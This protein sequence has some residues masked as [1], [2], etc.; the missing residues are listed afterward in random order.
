MPAP[1][2]LLYADVVEHLEKWANQRG[3]SPNLELI[4]WSTVRA[5]E[6]V[7][8]YHDWTFLLRPWRLHLKAPQTTGTIAYDYTGGTHERMVTLTG[9]TW[10]SWAIDGVIKFTTASGNNVVS[11]V[12]TVESTTVLTLDPNFCPDADV[13]AGTSYSL[14]RQYYVLPADFLSIVGIV[15]ENS[16]MEVN[17]SAMPSLL[18]LEKWDDTTGDVQKYCVAEAPDMFGSLAVYLWPP[19]DSDQ[20][21]DLTIKRHARTLRYCGQDVAL[22]FPGNVSVVSDSAAIAG[23]S[24]KFEADMV[25]SII[26]LSRNSSQPTSYQGRNPFVEERAIAAVADLLAATADSTFSATRTDVGYIIS[27]PI[28]LNRAAYP[29]VMACTEKFLGDAL[30]LEDAGRLF[31]KAERALQQAAGNDKRTRQRRIAGSF[32]YL[33]KRL[34]DYP[35]DSDV[36]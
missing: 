4:K 31:A 3:K 29:A 21:L 33:H 27:D 18:S 9:N 16:W 26:R 17:P 32:N 5:Y 20:T 22:E 7:T 34:A 14:Y 25:N 1:R 28:D 24:T 12:A 23:T 8:N 36:Q 19:I 30:G 13:A 35:Y 2:L 11:R 15:G 10:P 6:E